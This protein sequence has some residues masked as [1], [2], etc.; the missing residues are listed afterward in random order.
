MAS[1]F[2]HN[3][4]KVRLIPGLYTRLMIS[5]VAA[6]VAYCAALLGARPVPAH[7]QGRP[8]AGTSG[9][10][11]A[12]VVLIVVDQ[13]RPDY[14]DRFGAQFTGGFARIRSQGALFTNGRQDHAV[15][16]TAPGHATFMSGREPAHTE[17]VTN[18]KGV[19]DV[20]A[21]LIGGVQGPGASPRRFVGTTLY[22]WIVA[23][24]SAAR[25]LSVSRKD[26]GAIL[27]VGRAKGDV[28][29]FADGRFTTSTY[30][31]DALPTWVTAYDD[32]IHIERLA[33]TTWDLLLR[34]PAAYP[35]PDSV[36]AEHGGV[37]F[38]FPHTLPD[39]A[40]LR[41]AL[42]EYPWM[43][44]LTLHFALAGVRTLAL[45]Q[46]RGAGAMPDFLSVS[47][48]TTDAIGHAYGPGSRELHDHLL[49]LDR[50]LGAFL[51]SLARYVPRDRMLL[52]LSSDHGIEPLPELE[53]P[54]THTGGRLW[55]ADIANVA[56][57]EL[58]D[59]YHTDFGLEFDN[60]L[61]SADVNAMRA[62]GIRVDSVAGALAKAA[63][64]RRGI[65]QAYTPRS[66]AAAPQ[67]DSAAVRWRRTIPS[68]WGWLLAVNTELGYV[69]SP[70]RSIAEHATPHPLELTVPIAFMGP[71]IAP[72]RYTRLV[73]T[74]DIAPTLAALLGLKPTEPLDGV[75]IAE[76]LRARP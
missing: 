61:L 47:L 20:A 16:E 42:Q 24:D 41:G 12:L 49:R 59:R 63:L 50:W 13:L 74:V 66:L 57:A 29:W 71:G 14:L 34:D 76:I 67:S 23:R 18:L 31:A 39:A 19:P 48:S 60:G 9:G 5:R 21:P 46:R 28:Y 33:G 8:S 65:A 25:V 2:D 45:G 72:A 69:W 1:P 30:Y 37:D 70:G 58:R 53:V 55:L 51:D 64:E 68:A 7:S 44:S 11:T 26:R 43:D 17:I 62:R 4:P 15:T 32:S 52:V 6:I 35:E 36:A 10:T 22:D 3:S 75:P 38:T 56:G 27:P 73:R 40:A 54:R